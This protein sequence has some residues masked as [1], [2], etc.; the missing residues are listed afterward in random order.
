MYVSIKNL[1]GGADEAAGGDE[2]EDGPTEEIDTLVVGLWG[3]PYPW[4]R[5]RCGTE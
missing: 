5:D 3:K 2:E 1:L 4:R